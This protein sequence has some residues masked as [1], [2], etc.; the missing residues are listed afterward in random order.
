MISM[1]YWENKGK[2]KDPT[3]RRL[4]AKMDREV[5]KVSQVY[6]VPAQQ[7]RD[8]ADRRERCSFMQDLYDLCDRFDARAL[9]LSKEVVDSDG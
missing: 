4:R 2:I 7:V 3:L 1:W 5:K 9:E 6:Q 8:W